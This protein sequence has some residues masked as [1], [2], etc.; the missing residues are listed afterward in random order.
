MGKMKSLPVA[1]VSGLA[2]SLAGVCAVSGAAAQ[3]K[4]TGWL[5]WRGPQQDGTSAEKGLPSVWKPGGENHLWD[6]KLAAR[7]TPV[8]AN[9]KLYV[10]GYEG[11]GP[12]LRE[13]LVCMDANTGQRQWAHY[14]NDFLSDI[15]YNRY[16]IGSPTVDPETG[17]VYVLSSAGEFACFSGDGKRQWGHSLMEDLGRLTFPN[18]R[19]G[20]AIIDGDL[21]II[22]AITSNWGAEGPAADRFYAYDKRTGDLVWASTPGDRPKDNSFAPPLLAW[23]DGKRVM[24][25]GTGCGNLVCVNVRTGQPIWKYPMSAGGINSSVVLHKD[26]AIAI[27]D[28]EN[29]DTSEIGRMIAVNINA[30]AKPAEGG[31]T[32]VLDKGAEVWR[33]NLGAF[34]T[35]P[36]LVGDRIYQMSSKGILY[37]VDANTGKIQWEHRL[38]PDE[39]HASP[40]YADGKLYV[41]VTNGLFYIL[42]P[43]DTGVEEL[44][45]VQLEGQCLGAPAV[46]NGK[47]Y[48]TSTEK[49]YCFGSRSGGQPPRPAPEAAA[50]KPGP[51]VALQVIPNEVTLRPGETQKFR[52][53]GIDA[54]GVVTGVYPA[55][56]VKWAKFIPPTARVRSEMNAS[57]NAQGELVAD[58][59][60]TPSAGA[61][62]A[63]VGDLKGTFRGRILPGLPLKQDFEGME[64]TETTM[65]TPPVKFAY[66]PLP[67]IGA[68]FKWDVREIDGNKVLA[69]TLDNPLFQRSMLFLSQPETR[70]YTL[71][72]DVMSDGNRRSQSTIGLINQRYAIALSGNSQELEVSSNHER[73][74]VAVPFAWQPKVWYRM[75]TRVDVAPDG[76]GMVRAK[77][78]KKGD[79]EPAAWTLE[80]PHKNAHQEGAPGIFGFAPQSKF[81]VYV[82]NISVTPNK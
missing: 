6:V 77:V 28:A 25:T 51:A 27:H 39:L 44:T 22:R 46:W 21:V 31:G 68:R 47:V 8:V 64:L 49:V 23:K 7:G 78:W 52:V 19:T 32:P 74:K 14:F 10:F 63:T 33:N 5:S 3:A 69:K 42:K 60:L 20:S 73:L 71:E 58:A 40:L 75:V 4:A 79:A 65:D 54:N 76:A 82:D 66:P 9:G 15:I 12:D 55:N 26:K 50:P 29:L 53:R 2:L 24:Y 61:F 37:A 17:N 72:A 48:V 43:T 30:A 35:S 62:Q 18:G 80:V 41:P 56:Q 59:A 57:F 13:A 11:D 70:S 67:W 1:L 16:S 81:S 45:K 38:G 36:V 34:S